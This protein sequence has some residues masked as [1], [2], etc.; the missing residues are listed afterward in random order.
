MHHQGN[1]PSP[2]A[3]GCSSPAQEDEGVQFDLLA[4]VLWLHPVQLTVA[5][6][7]RE[8]SDAPEDFDERDSVERA[9]HDL[10]R[11]GLLHRHGAFVLPTRAALRFDQLVK[12]PTDHSRRTGLVQ[13][14]L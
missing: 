4:Q 9:V 7:L 2:S 11:A 3:R 5:E 14:K 12:S 1:C 6:L 10:T 8:L 13:V